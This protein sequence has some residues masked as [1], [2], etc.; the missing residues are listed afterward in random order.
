MIAVWL[1]LT[2][3]GFALAIVASRYATVY[4]QVAALRVGVPPLIIG[5]TLVGIGTNLP[6]IAN[7]VIA[8]LSDHGDLNAGAAIGSVAVDVT[9]V[10]GLLP[11]FAGAFYFSRIDL[12]A[13]AISIMFALGLGLL[14]VLD[15]ELS[16][17]DGAV[18]LLAWAAGTA[19]IWTSGSRLS[20]AEVRETS[21]GPAATQVLATIGALVVVAAGASI[22]VVGLVNVAEIA[23][24]PEYAISF[25]GTSIGTSLPEL[26]FD[27]IAVRRRAWGLA[28]GDAFGSAFVDATISLG[29]GP[30][31]AP[32]AV[33]TDLAVRGAIGALLAVGLV[34][35]V[36]W[37]RRR[38]DRPVGLLFIAAYVAL[39][40]L[41]LAT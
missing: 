39:Y 11:F 3:A 17:I 19:A 34:L 32:T 2:V 30:L 24:V 1:L 25:F 31:V 23:G 36:F 7:S 14:L 28:L 15:G 6:E 8:S 16:R 38:I 9:L 5:L 20:E 21:E 37:G 35:A 13:V 4:A 22:A 41:I 40:P 26:V 29:I 10:L 33:D 18:L 12:R 27:I